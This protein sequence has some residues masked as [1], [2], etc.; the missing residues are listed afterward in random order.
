MCSSFTVAP[1]KIFRCYLAER[2]NLP[3]SFRGSFAAA[4]KDRPEDNRRGAMG[5]ERGGV[6]GFQSI[7]REQRFQWLALFFPPLVQ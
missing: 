7:F 4:G 6:G 1:Q 5:V 3:D 2:L